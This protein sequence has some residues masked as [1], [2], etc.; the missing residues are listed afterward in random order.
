MLGVAMPSFLAILCFT[1]AVFTS[2]VRITAFF[3]SIPFFLASAKVFELSA[4]GFG[5]PLRI[6]V[7]FRN[8]VEYWLSRFHLQSR[9]PVLRRPHMDWRK[10]ADPR[11]VRYHFP[12]LRVLGSSMIVG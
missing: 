5:C 3:H 9:I 11:Q 7:F 10:W 2:A 12:E 4:C 8:P 6:V 1:R